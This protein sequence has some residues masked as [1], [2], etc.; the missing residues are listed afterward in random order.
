MSTQIPMDP[1]RALA[2]LELVTARGLETPDQG[3]KILADSVS[4]KFK[5]VLNI[6]ILNFSSLVGRWLN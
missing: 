4:K 1:M 2:S 3:P 5:R 6:Y